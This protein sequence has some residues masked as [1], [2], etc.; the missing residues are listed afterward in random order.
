MTLTPKRPSIVPSLMLV[1]LAVLEES[2]QTDTQTE[3]RFMYQ[4]S[5]LLVI[6]SYY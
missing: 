2:R 1:H 4:T 5:V 3:L 6:K